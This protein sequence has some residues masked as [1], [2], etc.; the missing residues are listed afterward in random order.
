MRKWRMRGLADAL[1][2]S[3]GSP[4]IVS[5]G[6]GRFRPRPT[7][8]RRCAGHRDA[9]FRL[10]F[11]SNVDGNAAER[12]RRA[13][14]EA[15][16]PPSSFRPSTPGKPCSTAASSTRGG[17]D[18]RLY[19]VS[20]NSNASPRS[21]PAGT[22]LPMWDWSVAAIRCNGRQSASLIALALGMLR[23]EALL[24]GAGGDGP[25][26]RDAAPR[27]NSR[28]G[29]PLTA[30]WNRN[31]LHAAA[32]AVLLH[33]ERLAAAGYL[34]QLVMESLASRWRFDGSPLAAQTVPVWVGRRRHRHQHSFF[35]ALHQ[36]TQV[37]PADFIGVLPG[38]PCACGATMRR[39][40]R[41]CWRRPRRW[42]TAGM[43]RIRIAAIPATA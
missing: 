40:S 9:R 43:P 39:C 3:E 1:A 4:D 21:H 15:Q 7:A 11:I 28:C 22:H 25:A 34:Q 23:F 35:Q 10:H 31:G 6:I 27:E 12:A 41:T 30:V 20:S 33:D 36:G 19:A 18:N 2:A 24:A 29:T 16:H 32:Q 17:D 42:R 26:C 38:R 8:G 14:S 37:V 13:G 5:I